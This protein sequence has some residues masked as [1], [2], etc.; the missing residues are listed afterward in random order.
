MHTK[1]KAIRQVK[2]E[3]RDVV[4]VCRK[5]SKKLDGGFGPDGKTSFVKALRRVLP[6]PKGKARKRPQMILEVGCFDVCPKGAVVALRADRPGGWLIIPKGT[7]IDEAA[8]QLGLQPGTEP[9]EAGES[10]G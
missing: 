5:C 2:S 10:A 1:Q 3:W 7:P 9:P 6:S 4:L 8:R